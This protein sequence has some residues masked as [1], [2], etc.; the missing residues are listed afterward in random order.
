MEVQIVNMATVKPALAVALLVH[1]LHAGRFAAHTAASSPRLPHFSSLWDAVHSLPQ[2]SAFARMADACNPSLR[3]LLM[4]PAAVVR[5]H[6]A[7]QCCKFKFLPLQ[8]S[9]AAC[10]TVRR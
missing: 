7:C 8:S 2:L 1:V 6:A 5:F 9:Q 3:D 4:D 10:S